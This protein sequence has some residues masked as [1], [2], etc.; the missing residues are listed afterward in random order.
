MVIWVALGLAVLAACLI[1]PLPSVLAR[2]QWPERAPRA[3]VVLWQVVGLTA[4][5]SAVGAGL[6]IAVAP[7]ATTVTH[8]MHR[9]LSQLF[10]GQLPAEF[11]W[12]QYLALLWAVGFTAFLVWRCGRAVLSTLRKRREHRDVVDMVAEAA[13]ELGADVDLIQHDAPAAYCIPGRLTRIVVSTG[14][15]RILGSSETDAVLAHERAHARSRH[16]LAV[17][18]FT[19]LAYAMP[20]LASTRRAR[21]AVSLLVEMLADDSAR[22]RYGSHVLARA[23]TRFAEHTKTV[24]PGALGVGGGTTVIRVRRLLTE[25]PPIPVW[26]Q[27]VVYLAASSLLMTP[28][29]VALAPL[30]PVFS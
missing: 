4:A 26:Q 24:P 5:L 22:R 13:P 10:T 9:L 25:A 21:D 11:A 6:G 19:A 8:G 17:L 3:A 23:L 16:D 1:G 30:L 18:P 12:Y 29:L 14:A 20:W 7:L 28:V 15:L 27:G 2:A